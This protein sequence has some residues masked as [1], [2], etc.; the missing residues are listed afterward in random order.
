[1]IC[2]INRSTVDY[3]VRLHKYVQACKDTK[4]PYFVIGWDR[5]L[6]AKFV[7]EH[8]YQLKLYCPYAQGKKLI[9]AIRWFFFMWYYLLKNFRKYK[10][11][12]AC[13][14]ENALFSLPFKLL[15]KK[16][17]F[18]VYDSQ[19]ISLERKIATMVD[20][21]V[22][23]A[24]KR[25]EQIGIEK[26]CLKRFLEIENVPTFN[27]SVEHVEGLK[28]DKIYLSYV[29]V[30]QKNIRGLENL[31]NMV[32]QDNRFVLDIAGVGDDLESML[33]EAANRCNRINYHGKVQYTE[34]LEIMNKSDFIIAL[35]YPYFSNHIFASPNKSY[36]A[37]FL[38]TPIIT[39]IGTLVGHKVIESNTGYVVDD[40]LNG[41]HSFFKDV[42]T[43]QFKKEYDNKVNN[44]K[45]LWNQVYVDYRRKIL[46]GEYLNL[47]RSLSDKQS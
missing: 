31:V 20:C 9:P 42:D 2:Y 17:V 46:E 43:M 27:I 47:V 29:G 4:T 3:D 5:M 22:L 16:I 36:E 38:A 13:N 34:A 30:F 39:S 15:G 37:L 33:I 24:E 11:I 28:C 45:L 7:D 32:L 40:T 44:C 41:L 8:E 6:N 35:Y 19:I 26:R 14:M 12:H 23:P 10:V 1:M 18:D 25:L 21:L